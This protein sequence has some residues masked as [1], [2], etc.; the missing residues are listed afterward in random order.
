MLTK[1]IKEADS[2]CSME[3]SG[4]IDPKTFFDDV[5]YEVRSIGAEESKIQQ[6]LKRSAE[7]LTR[8][9]SSSSNL[10][11]VTKAAYPELFTLERDIKTE[12]R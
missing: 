8:K 12:L 10:A 11:S 9:Q 4:I 2:L 1:L 6:T 7:H 5:L 3:A